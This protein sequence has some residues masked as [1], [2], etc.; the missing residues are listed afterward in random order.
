MAGAERGA[1][2]S[3]LTVRVISAAVMLAVVALALWLGGWVMR[4]LIAAVALAVMIELAG[5]LRKI[6][7]NP[8][9]RSAALAAG[10]LYVGAAALSMMMLP[11]EVLVLVIA[12]VV[13]TDTGAYFAGRAIGGPKIAPRISPSKTWAGLAGGM[14]AAA[15]VCAL[16]IGGVKYLV[17]GIGER[18]PDL[19]G[20]LFSRE[21]GIA[22]LAGALLAVVA[23]A[24]D[25]FESWLK[26]RAGV[27]DSS[28]LIP[29]HGGV[30][31]RVDG[32]IAVS[33]V[34]GGVMLAFGL[35]DMLR[36]R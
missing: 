22:A 31:D 15:A 23:Q 29:G 4:G 34:V 27:K 3:D 19:L 32:L 2:Q 12:L 5:L 30:F 35:Y 18:G 26:R 21:A 17:S 14:V 7:P 8:A 20:S 9:A 33:F 10:M 11:V 36:L 25:F 1:K 13:G 28:S 16:A 6:F 24:G